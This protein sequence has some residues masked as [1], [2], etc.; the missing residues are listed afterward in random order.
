MQV[1]IRLPEK[2][3]TWLEEE[4]ARKRATRTQVILDS[5]ETVRR[6]EEAERFKAQLAEESRLLRTE[7]R[8]A[9]EEWLPAAS[10]LEVKDAYAA[11]L[12]E[13]S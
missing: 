11:D 8:K 7:S 4:V 6:M 13:N 10:I 3:A 2:L 1:S 5:L 12:P 9:A